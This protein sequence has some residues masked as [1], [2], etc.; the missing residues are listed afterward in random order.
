MQ[1]QYKIKRNR[2]HCLQYN[3]ICQEKNRLTYFRDGLTAAKRNVFV[4]P[5]RE[6]RRRKVNFESR[7]GICRCFPFVISTNAVMTFP[8]VESDLLI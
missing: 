1:L 7:Y 6:S 5:P 8:R 4:F 3:V 2:Q